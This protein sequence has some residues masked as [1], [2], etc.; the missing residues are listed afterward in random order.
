MIGFLTANPTPKKTKKQSQ[1][2][3]IR[4]RRAKNYEEGVTDDEE[5][6]ARKK[7]RNFDI[8]ALPQEYTYLVRDEVEE[9]SLWDDPN[10]KPT[11]L[12]VR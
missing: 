9:L 7:R 11:R 3:S 8:K 12:K 4:A 1:K 6:S 10:D 5:Q 2:K